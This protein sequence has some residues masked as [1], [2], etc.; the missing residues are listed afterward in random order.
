MNSNCSECSFNTQLPYSWPYSWADLD[1]LNAK[2]FFA[3]TAPPLTMFG[4]NLTDQ[5]LTQ[6]SIFSLGQLTLKLKLSQHLGDHAG[7]C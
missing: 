2:D 4:N 6:R 1:S 3:L 5:S 7:V